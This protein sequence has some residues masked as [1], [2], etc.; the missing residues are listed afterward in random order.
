[1][2]AKKKPALEEVVEEIGNVVAILDKLGSRL[3][4]TYVTYVDAEPVRRDEEARATWVETLAR[5]VDAMEGHLDNVK[6][7]RAA[8]GEA[9]CRAMPMGTSL[10]SFPGV[11]PM[12]PRWSSERKE[13]RNDLLDADLSPRL[14]M[15]GEIK[16]EDGRLVWESTG[17]KR[18]PEEM[19]ETVKSVVSLI[20]SNVKTTGL[21]KLGLSVDDYCRKTPAPPDVQ[22]TK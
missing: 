18:D 19:L 14:L 20:G 3:Q 9:L 8:A 15:R 5:Y 22:I 6:E 2:P 1:M 7:I 11:R 13:W 16:E 12:T 10:I 21:R 17:E 4:Q